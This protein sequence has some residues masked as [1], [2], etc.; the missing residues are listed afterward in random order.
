MAKKTEEPTV[1]NNYSRD[2]D[3]TRFLWMAFALSMTLIIG[4]F[5][6]ELVHKP[7]KDE[8][9][10]FTPEIVHILVNGI[11]IAFFGLGTFI[12]GK[13]VGANEVLAKMAGGGNGNQQ[14]RTQPSGSRT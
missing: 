1:D 5:V 7:L 13:N 12:Y 14:N 10:L 2:A 9:T 8:V 3:Q 11:G 6:L 4:L